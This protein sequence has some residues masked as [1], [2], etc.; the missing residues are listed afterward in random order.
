MFA[1]GVA[2]GREMAQPLS[3][4]EAEVGRLK[5]ELRRLREEAAKNE[6]ILRRSQGRELK[7]LNAQTLPG[8]LTVLVDEFRHSFRLKEVTVVLR[9]PQHEVRHLLMGEGAE[10]QKYPNVIFSDSLAG[11]A[12]QYA[13][14]RRPWLGPYSQSDHQ[15]VFPRTQGLKSIALLPLI[16][17]EHLIGALNFG[18]SDP[19]RFTRE[20]ATDILEHL[21]TVAA[22]CLE[23]A[24][25]RA[26]LRRSGVIDVLTGWHNRRYLKTRL[27]EE[28]ARARRE[29]QSLVC[30]MLDVDHFKS[31]NDTFGHAAGD[32]VL[33][34]VA[35]RIECE[36]RASDVAARYGGEEFVVLLPNTS[37]QEATALAERV[38]KSVSAEPIKLGSDRWHTVTVSIGIAVTEP[39]ADVED[40][41]SVGEGL[42][43]EADVALYR[44]KSHGRNRIE[45]HEEAA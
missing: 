33:R 29:G 43:A 15:L 44:A 4:F 9:D 1:N 42:L 27:S 21:A 17:Q 2:G 20:H 34:E 38:R 10:P 30:L 6:T 32:D 23:N 3:G 41:K 12:T 25:N 16:R 13:A 39:H 7:L 14:M 18:S 45:V 28:L 35:Q 24:V 8:L 26:R 19:R 37:T 22:F 40:L 31:I 36:V 5:L 11:L